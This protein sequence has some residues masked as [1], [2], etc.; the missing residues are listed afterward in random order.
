MK[1]WLI[2][3]AVLFLLAMVRVGVHVLY[4]EKQLQLELL[5]SRFKL[6]LV[7]TKKEKSQRN[8]SQR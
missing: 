4:E 1:G 8:P 3:L 5:I 2:A 6:L 7:G